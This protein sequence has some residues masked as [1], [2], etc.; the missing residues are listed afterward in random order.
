MTTTKTVPGTGADLHVRLQG[1]GPV[2]LVLQGGDGTAEGADPLVRHLTD[3][4]TVVTYDR[5]GLGR[6][7]V[8]DLGE[9]DLST[10]GEDA[11]RVLAAVTDEPA[12]VVGFSIGGLIALDLLARHPGQVRALVSHE[13]P[14]MALLRGKE[15]EEAVAELTDIIDTHREAGPAVA[16]PKLM[17]LA[18]ITPPP[19]MPEPDAARL[20]NLDFFLGED[21]PAV[22]RHQPDIPALKGKPLVIGLG[23]DTG[24]ITAA[25]CARALAEELGA[26]TADFPGGH[27]GFLFHP[28]E[29]ADRLRTVL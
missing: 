10:H 15:S 26:A 25:R 19:T 9:H 5:R 14:A 6:S 8:R 17:G 18:G 23:R 7:P 11:S 4:F 2:L 29:F 22:L 20:A 21:M 1:S 27:S 24:D 12:A 3:H 28:E 16:G 13:P